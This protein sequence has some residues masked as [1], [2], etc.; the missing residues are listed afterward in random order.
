MPFFRTSKKWKKKFL[1]LS[2]RHDVEGERERERE[3]WSEANNEKKLSLS[4]SL[5]KGELLKSV[6]MEMST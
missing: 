2:P 4:H 1:T 3:A 6:E 5:K